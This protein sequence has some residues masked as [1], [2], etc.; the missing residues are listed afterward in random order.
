MTNVLWYVVAKVVSIPFIAEYLIKRAQR[1]PYF[2]LEGYMDRWWLFNGYGN[3]PNVPDEKRHERRYKWL[4]SI[5]I[6]H[7]L[8]EDF[9][10]DMHDHPWDARTI[11]LK[12]DYDEERM[13]QYLGADQ[14]LVADFTRKAGDTA[15]LNY[16]EYHN[17]VRV[18][19]GGVWTIFITYDYKG[20]WGFLVDGVKVPHNQYIDGGRP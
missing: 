8:R 15:T 17:I 1:T 20:T 13:I 10:R 9:A 14:E 11:I 3:N 6:H 4:P 7:I 18:S 12:G 19:E 16:G 2:H 5:R